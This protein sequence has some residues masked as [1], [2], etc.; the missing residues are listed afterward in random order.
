MESG[1]NILAENVDKNTQE[2]YLNSQSD[3]ISE[4]ELKEQIAV[5]EESMSALYK[6][7]AVKDSQVVTLPHANGGLF[8]LNMHKR[9][10]DGFVAKKPKEQSPDSF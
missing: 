10:N 9:E 3:K 4:N 2:V 8:I 1:V 7:G 5:L 6:A